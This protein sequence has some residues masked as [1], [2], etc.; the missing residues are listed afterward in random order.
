MTS[1]HSFLG[2]I[3]CK[4]HVQYPAYAT[5]SSELA[6]GVFGLFVSFVQKLPQLHSHTSILSHL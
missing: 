4:G 6:A 2:G 1:L 3:E 5:G